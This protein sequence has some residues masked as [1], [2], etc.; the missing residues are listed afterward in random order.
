VVVK[1][2]GDGMMAA[3]DEAPNALAAV[4]EARDRLATVKA[5]GYNPRIRAGIH[6]GAPKRL[7]DD[8]FGVDVNIA[9]RVAEEAGADEV[10]VS[11]AT[12][13]AL[14]RDSVHA[15]RK[16]LFRAKGVPGDVAVYAI[17]GVAS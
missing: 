4:L 9:A 12:L 17:K 10:L 5:P 8:F 14:D 6:L 11:A 16:L 7:G 1:R 2:L 3:F 13:E 15:K